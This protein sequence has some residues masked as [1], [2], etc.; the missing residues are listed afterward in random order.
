MD[1]I[2]SNIFKFADKNVLIYLNTED[3]KLYLNF[4]NDGDKIKD[5]DK[6]WN[7]FYTEKGE[8]NKN[9]SG[10]GTTIIK[11]I[12]DHSKIDITIENFN[13]GVLYKLNLT[14]I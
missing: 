7:I 13:N 14:Q 11:N 2:F 1:N 12:L 9:G 6:I 10:L 8:K 4:Y 5:I 3:N